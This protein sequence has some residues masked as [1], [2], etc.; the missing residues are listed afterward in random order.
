MLNSVLQEKIDEVSEAKSHS[1]VKRYGITIGIHNG[2]RT[3]KTLTSVMLA[4]WYAMNIPEIQGI[5]SNVHLKNLDRIGLEGKFRPITDLKSIGADEY[6]NF[7]LLTDEFRSII[8]SRMSGS[9]KNL[10][11]SNILRDTGKMKQI[12]ILTDQDANAIERRVRINTDL[13]LYPQVNP[14]DATCTVKI[15]DGYDQFYY[16]R[17]FDRIDEWEIE[18]KYNIMDWVDYYDTEQKIDEYYLTFEP[19]E[20]ANKFIEWINGT[21]YSKHRD[22]VIKTSTLTL[23][24]EET[25]EFISDSQKSA[26]MEWLRYNTKYPMTGRKKV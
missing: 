3:G 20:Y 9:F 22:F 15:F 5:L 7:I 26:L 25:G 11:I 4:L 18:F 23:W 2:A 16:I 1:G 24:K 14:K 8:D 21:G 10:F 12:H 6:K 17:G 19:Q 13:V